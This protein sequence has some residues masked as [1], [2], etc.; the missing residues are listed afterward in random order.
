MNAPARVTALLPRRS[1]YDGLRRRW[2]NDLVAGLTVAVVALPLALAFGITTGLGAAAGLTTAIVAGVVAAVFGGSNLQVSGPTGAM[3]VVLVPLVARHGAD[4]VII[5]GVLAGLLVIAGA[6]LRLGRYLAY[7]PWPV[8]EGFT[9][10]IAVI[11]A[12]QQ[13]PN[14]LG[15]PKPEGENTAVVAGRAVADA[16]G[17]VNLA[18]VGLVALVAVIMVVAPRLHRS[19]PASL[20]A[21]LAATVV[22]AVADLDVTTIGTLPQALPTLHLPHVAVGDLDRYLSAAFAIAALAAIESLLSAKV[23]DG[24]ADGPRHDPDRE[25]FGQG[26]ANVVSPLL[27]GM[28]A[29]GA[30]ARTA[31][32]VRAGARTRVAALV[33][34]VTLVAVVLFAASLVARIPL[35]A[36]AGVLIVTAVRMVDVHNI[37]AVLRSTRSDAIVL[38][39]T[40]VATVVFDLIVAVEIGVAA[41]AVLALRHVARTAEAVPVTVDPEVDPD[42]ERDLLAEHIVAYRLDGALFFGAAQRFLTELAAVADVEVVILRLPGLQVLDA[43][44]AQ[45]LGEIVDELEHR[46][47]TVLLKGPRPEHLKVLEA[48]GALDRLAHERHLFDDLDAAV[49]HARLHVGRRST[50]L[51]DLEVLEADV[52]GVDDVHHV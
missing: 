18:A 41:A 14:A 12:L 33:H 26:L 46:G 3:T 9:L 17:D 25:L 30:I 20:L 49:A 51:G 40:A 11:I 32:N 42:A 15:V 38:V 1:D 7:I 43:T 29:T 35:A 19:L 36:L 22:A 31:V 44:G 16:I 5:A 8:V 13:V 39:L 28:P 4:G 21:V 27:G 24:M 2:R 47:I 34:S 45:A 50:D 37:R 52:E 10:G 6:L 48:V 23:A